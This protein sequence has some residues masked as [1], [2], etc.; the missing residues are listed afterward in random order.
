MTELAKPTPIQAYFAQGYKGRSTWPYWLSGLFVALFIW[1]FFQ[2]ILSFGMIFEIMRVDPEGVENMYSGENAE[3]LAEDSATQMLAFFIMFLLG[4]VAIIMS[5]I[6]ATR[7]PKPNTGLMTAAGLISA[8]GLLITFW[9]LTQNDAGFNAVL[10]RNIPN[11]PALYTMML[12][13]F[14]PL[15]FG[16][17]LVTK[18]IHGRPFKTLM[19]AHT[20]FRWGRVFQTMV[21]YWAI[22]GVV[23]T[24]CHFLG[25]NQIEF[26]FNSG[27]FLTFAII[28]LLLIPLQS[29]TEEIILRG[30]M[31]QGLGKYIKNPWIVFFIT[32]FAFASLHLAN[33]EAVAGASEG[34]LLITMSGYFF[35]G[36]FACILTYIDGGLESA[37]G[38]HVANNLFA[39]VF[40]GYDNSV[41]PTPTVYKSTLNPDTDW[42]VTLIV[43]ALATL[44][45]WKFRSKL[46]P[47]APTREDIEDDMTETFS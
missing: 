9:M 21:I 47:D 35:F 3:A 45:L 13:A 11:S 40:M 17:W 14:P 44:I 46:T 39:A 32:S 4:L 8:I 10:T 41:L 25:L 7:K 16:L 19:T 5:F 22:I 12:L 27:A 31:N 34:K 30:Y 38:M 28:S 15:I 1:M 42:I 26:V 2:V 6:G 37:I 20:K 43:L 18:V 23:A 24:A 36:Y 29:A 33:P